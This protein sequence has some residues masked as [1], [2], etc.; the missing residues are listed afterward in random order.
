MLQVFKYWVG[1]DF[2]KIFSQYKMSNV[3]ILMILLLDL[4]KYKESSGYTTSGIELC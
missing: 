2:V 4:H 1:V 3:I